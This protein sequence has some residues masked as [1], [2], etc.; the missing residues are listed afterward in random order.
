MNGECA[1]F[2]A[3]YQAFDTTTQQHLQIRFV[4]VIVDDSGNR[5]RVFIEGY[6]WIR[7]VLENTPDD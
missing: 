3:F 4:D 5:L 6:C 2:Q 7:I 1:V